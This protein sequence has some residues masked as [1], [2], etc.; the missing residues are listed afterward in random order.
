MPFILTLVA[1]D[2]PLSA[3]HL[4][5]VERF[6]DLQGLNLTGDPAWLDPHKAADIPISDCL[7]QDQM[8]ELRAAFQADR[9][10]VFCSPSEN[11]RKKLLIADMDSTIVTSETLDELADFAEIKEEISAIT[12]RAMNGELDFAAALKQRVALLKGLPTDALKK[13]LSQIK[14]SGGAKQLVKTMRNNG[15]VCVLVSGGFTFFTGAIA[16]QVGFSQHH[17]NILGVE[18]GALTGEVEEPIL[19][20][21]SKLTF[22]RQ[23]T[24]DLEL[25]STDTM[26][27]GDGANDLPMLQSA[28]LGIGYRPKPILEESLTNVILYGDLAA[29][30]YAQGYT[31]EEI[32]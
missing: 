6:A 12:A 23:Y 30:L 21:N 4:A 18:G 17:G 19:D 28:A 2:K 8:G 5:G 16:G 9:I 24:Q 11:R 22:L 29:A 20:K 26:A 14:I 15:A 7:D 32:A 10:D 3:A 27:I 13:T 25:N 31:K 1:S